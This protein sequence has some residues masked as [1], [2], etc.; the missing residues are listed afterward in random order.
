MFFYRIQLP[1][2]G[3]LQEQLF[4]WPQKTKILS[5]HGK[6]GEESDN[7]NLPSGATAT[8]AWLN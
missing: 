1:K 4:N 2:R 8:N 3:G 5:I 6:K 7:F